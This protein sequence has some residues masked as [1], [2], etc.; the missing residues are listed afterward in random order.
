MG[1]ETR[2]AER[3]SSL[4]EESRRVVLPSRIHNLFITKSPNVI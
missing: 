2:E 3:S 4:E 1:S